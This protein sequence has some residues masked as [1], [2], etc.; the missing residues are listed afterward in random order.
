MRFTLIDRIVELK[1]GEKITA[2]KNV[3]LAEEYLQDH[4]PKFPVLPGVLMLE[5]MTQACAWL[6]RV[7]EDFAHS[8]VL[9]KEA[10]N[11]KYANF[12]APGH[13]LLVTAE[14]IRQDERLTQF[15]VLGTVDGEQVVS[16]RLVLERF[17]LA[18]N[19]PDEAAT[20]NHVKHDLRK[21][22]KLL[23]SGDISDKANAQTDD[24]STAGKT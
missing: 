10:R 20:D 8:M 2:V 7:S 6:I 1:P 15:K 19:H 18:D 4:F 5:A 3:S 23:Y 24:L 9:L 14:L 17:N 13:M 21:L 11:V 16:A 22:L 12:V